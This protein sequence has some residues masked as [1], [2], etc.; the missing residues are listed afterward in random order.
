MQAQRALAVHPQRPAPQHAPEQGQATALKHAVLGRLPGLVGCLK[1]PR[2]QRRTP[3]LPERVHA[4][5]VCV[6]GIMQTSGLGTS[7]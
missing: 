1:N 5:M 4:L 6:M 2:Q 3:A 7:H